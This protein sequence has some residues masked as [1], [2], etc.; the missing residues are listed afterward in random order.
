MSCEEIR[1]LI[2]DIGTQLFALFGADN[3]LLLY[4]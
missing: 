4:P 2:K 1:Q 3:F